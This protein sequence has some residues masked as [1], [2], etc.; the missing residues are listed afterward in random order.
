MSNEQHFDKLTIGV[1]RKFLDEL[2]EE[3]DDF[4]LVISEIFMEDDK[5]IRMDRE[6][7]HMQ[8]HAETKAFMLLPQTEDE[9][10]EVLDQFENGNTEETTE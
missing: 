8:V 3:V 7:V 4:G 6:I 10:E 5:F 9:L 2:P 1:L